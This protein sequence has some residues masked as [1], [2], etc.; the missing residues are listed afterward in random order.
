MAGEAAIEDHGLLSDCRSVALVTSDATVDWWCAPRMD[1]ASLFGA[2]L[3]AEDGGSCEIAVA[4]EVAPPRRRYLDATL[5]LET[6]LSDRH[7]V[8]RV[9]DCLV[10][11]VQAPG[12]PPGQL[13]RVLEPVEGRPRVRVRVA[14]RFDYG[15]ATPW[16]RRGGRGGWIALG[17]DDGLHIVS[18]LPLDLE[19]DGGGVLTAA[20][21]L[22]ARRR[23]SMRFERP[24][25]LDGEPPAPPAT[26][27]LD[28][29]LAATTA[30]W[31]SWCEQIRL[32]D[33]DA[34]GVLRSALTLR[35]LTVLRTGAVAAAATTSLPESWSG[36]TWDYRAAWIRDA[37]FGVR[38]LAEL[39][40]PAE[41]DGF[42]R[43]VQRSAAGRAAELRIAYGLGGERRLPENELPAPAGWRGIGPV[44]VGNAALQQHQSDAYGELLELSWR[45]HRHGAHPDADLWRFLRDLVDRAAAAWREPDRGLWEWRGE[46]RHF[47]HSKALCWVALDRGVRLAEELGLEAPIDRWRS[48]RDAC[49]AA[50]LD[51]GVNADGV[52]VQAY[53]DAALDAAVLRIPMVGLLPYDDERV[54]R[55][56]DAL[57]ERLGDDGLV[58]RYDAD[59]GLAGREGAFLACTFWAAQ[60]LARQGRRDRAR[61]LFERGLATRNDVGLFSE[62]HDPERGAA[63]G[64]FPQALSHLSHIDAALALDGA[65]G[66]EP[67]GG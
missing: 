43:F 32:P 60:V 67:P 29:A 19:D 2:L 4:D 12:E 7:G 39:G 10:L 6:T 9:L 35:G 42:R 45:G 28:A 64:N 63:L 40:L 53:G 21:A 52:L 56:V 38:A 24:E 25:A 62:E 50:I 27:A 36:R 13:L 47:V 15:G 61:A 66:E 37:T 23:L 20:L 54:V 1:D 58:R 59:D 65:G 26:E 14:P 31:Q 57:L 17:G 48:E 11:D 44:R 16:I 30:S 3:D 46:P 8:A 22:R 41:A 33:V 18:D 49:R 34:A 5:V 51:R 55:T